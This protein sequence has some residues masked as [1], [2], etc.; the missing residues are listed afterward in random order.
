MTK[1]QQFKDLKRCEILEKST[2]Y[3]V[4]WAKLSFYTYK[5]TE[6][7]HIFCGALNMCLKRIVKKNELRMTT[8]GCR[9]II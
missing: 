6:V 9:D 5:M 3:T 8:P 1:L 4:I 7:N 2:V